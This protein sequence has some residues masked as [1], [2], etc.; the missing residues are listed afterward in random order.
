MSQLSLI[1]L[2][3][4]RLSTL[5][6]VTKYIHMK[7]ICLVAYLWF[8]PTYQIKLTCSGKNSNHHHITYSYY[9]YIKEMTVCAVQYLWYYI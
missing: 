2:A 9:V 4:L 5:F 6:G 7:P 1:K 3:K 8:L